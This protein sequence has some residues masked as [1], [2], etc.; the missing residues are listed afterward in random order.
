MAKIC[1]T[2]F[3]GWG[4]AG[5]EGV[6]QAV[7]DG[8]GWENEYVVCTSLP[9]TLMDEYRFKLPFML[10]DE[11]RQIYDVARMDYDIFLLGGGGLRWG[12][13]WQQALAAFSADKPC[14][15]YGLG[16][17]QGLYRPKL[18]ML[19][20]EFLRQFDAVTVR[21]EGSEQLL[22]E[23]GVDATLTMCPAINLK[24]EKFRGCP[25]NMIAVCPR[26]QDD[27]ANEPQITWLVNRLKGL[28][29]EVLLI[30]FARQDQQE[31][32]I[33]LA[34][35]QEIDRR[36]GGCQILNIDGY[37]PRRIKYAISRSKLVISGGRYHALVWAVAHDI[38][39]EVYPTAIETST[40]IKNFIEM[41][42]K[43][44]SGN[45]KTMEKQNVEIFKSIMR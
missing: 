22:A 12:F 4:N 38:P 28:R 9:F 31:T 3:Y 23:I 13:G 24:E 8:L 39:F 1:V 30:P 44:G 14:M 41:V 29:D 20:G 6:L 43:Y 27:G 35:C 17:K 34:V 45:L 32:P 2:G 11:V 26:F 37:S 7:F 25:E 16:V 5:D 19:F 15:V 40:K 33:D 10:V 21:D 18:K 36:L 42:K